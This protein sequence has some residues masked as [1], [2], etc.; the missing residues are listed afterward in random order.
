MIMIT[1]NI[2][3]LT[4][5]LHNCTHISKRIC[6]QCK[7]NIWYCDYKQLYLYKYIADYE[8]MPSTD[9][10]LKLI[11]SYCRIYAP[12][13]QDSIGSDNGLSA[14][15]HQGIIQ[16]NVGL[17]SCAFLTS[18]PNCAGSW[19][20]YLKSNMVGFDK[21]WYQTFWS[22][23]TNMPFVISIWVFELK[24]ITVPVAILP[25]NLGTESHS[26]LIPFSRNSV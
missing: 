18:T 15:R 14:Y 20:Q 3:N 12:V 25:R 26:R 22:T 24:T 23:N 1:H 11:S 19:C 2:H 21:T 13:T 4:V 9:S 16:T 5:T 8:H 10:K 6:V 7:W 17:L